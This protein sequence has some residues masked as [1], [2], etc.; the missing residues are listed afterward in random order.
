VCDDLIGAFQ[1]LRRVAV[2]LALRD[3]VQSQQ[4]FLQ[5]A[6]ALRGQPTLR[7]LCEQERRSLEARWRADLRARPCLAR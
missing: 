2:N 3:L 4:R 1:C 5:R 7:A 6:R